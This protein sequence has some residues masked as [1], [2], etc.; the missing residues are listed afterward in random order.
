[1][2]SLDKLKEAARTYIDETVYKKCTTK[3]A[4]SKD[5]STRMCVKLEDAYINEAHPEI[6]EEEK[7]IEKQMVEHEEKMSSLRDEIKRL[8]EEMCAQEKRRLDIIGMEIAVFEKRNAASQE[9]YVGLFD[10]L[11]EKREKRLRE[12]T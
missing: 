9:V 12:S 1:M 5:L 10:G 3:K 7:A 11:E 6:I 4:T 8:K 2:A